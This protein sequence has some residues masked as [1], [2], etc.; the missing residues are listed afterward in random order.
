MLSF[1]KT[2]YFLFHAL[3]FTCFILV[4]Q[5]LDE[6]F[7]NAETLRMIQTFDGADKIIVVI[8]IPLWHFSKPP[9]GRAVL[10]AEH[11]FDISDIK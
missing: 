11:M 8:V 4:R 3:S 2:L 5:V 7:I 6:A 9:S 1:K 10:V